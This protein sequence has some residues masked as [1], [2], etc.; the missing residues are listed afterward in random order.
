MVSGVLEGVLVTF[1]ELFFKMPLLLGSFF[2]GKLIFR[3]FRSIQGNEPDWPRMEEKSMEALVNF[4][5]RLLGVF[6]VLGLLTAVGAVFAFWQE[7]SRGNGGAAIAPVAVVVVMELLIW[8]LGF[9]F[10]LDREEIAE[11]VGLTTD[12]CFFLSLVL[13]AILR[14]KAW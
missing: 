13:A 11:S 3:H 1:F 12:T 6:R 8:V 10:K 9:L 5:I 4:G 2:R 7:A 14:L